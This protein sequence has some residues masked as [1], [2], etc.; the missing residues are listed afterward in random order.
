MTKFIGLLGSGG[1]ADEVELYIENDSEVAFRVVSPEY[2]DSTQTKQIT[3]SSAERYKNTPV[4]AA[5]GSPALRKEMVSLWGGNNYCTVISKESYIALSAKLGSGT[6]VAPM[7]V[8]TT[9]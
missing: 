4:V 8:L 9:N 5:V 3:F 2:L 6:I 7:A 1:Q